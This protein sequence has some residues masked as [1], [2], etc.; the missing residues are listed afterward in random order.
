MTDPQSVRNSGFV[1]AIRRLFPHRPML[2]AGIILLALLMKLLVPAG[3]M[4]GGSAGAVRIVPC[5]GLAPAGPIAPTTMSVMTMP[6]MAHHP[7]APDHARP[8]MPCA[9]AALTAPSLAGA[10][11]V[12]LAGAI[13]F[14]VM[15]AAPQITPRTWTVPAFLRPPL[16]GPPSR[17]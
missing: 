6:G 8:D 5:S 12:L 1:T 9:F 13:A 17:P 10:D 7:D 2:S 15:A 4:V 3:Y 14:I 16:R 11:P